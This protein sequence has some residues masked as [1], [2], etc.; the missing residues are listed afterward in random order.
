MGTEP[1]HEEKD[2]VHR[3]Q[4]KRPGRR[5]RLR[6]LRRHHRAERLVLDR[7]RRVGEGGAHHALP[8]EIDPVVAVGAG[9]AVDEGEEVDRGARP[10]GGRQQPLEVLELF[11]PARPRARTGRPSR[12][13]ASRSPPDRSVGWCG[14]RETRS[15][16]PASPGSR[17]RPRIP[18]RDRCRSRTRGACRPPAAVDPKRS[19][20]P[21]KTIGIVA[22]QSRSPRRSFSVRTASP[23]RPSERKGP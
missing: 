2:L 18:R 10:A 3:L 1:R 8:D 20:W 7:R 15:P 22:A 17:A 11:P 6:Q 23:V 13:P 5:L 14:P 9:I 19:P 12:P 16:S 4:R 21:L